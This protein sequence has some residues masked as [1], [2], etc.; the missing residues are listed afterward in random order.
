[1]LLFVSAVGVVLVVSFLC[2]IYE[3]VLL[4]VRRPRIEV[5]TREGRRS[6][7]LL[8]KF[9]DNM[10]VPIAAILILN[11]AAHT[12]GAAVAGASYSNVF[13]PS[14]LWLFS[15]LFTLAVLLFTEIIPKTLGVSYAAKLAPMVAHGIQWLT[16][17]LKPLVVVSEKI[18]RSIRGNVASPVTS[19]EEIRLLTVLG[20]AE[21]VVGPRT[22]Q[23]IVGASQ[24]S[25]L[26]A[27][28]VILPREEIRY[29]SGT[30]DRHTALATAHEARHSRFPFTPSGDLNDFTGV[31]LVKD[32]LHWLLTHEDEE[33]DWESL[34]IEPIVV[35]ESA[36]LTRLLRTFQDSR[37]HLA[38]VVDEYGSVEGLATLED[39]LE[40]IVGEIDDES[41]R[42]AKDI[43]E[44]DDGS[45]FVK[46]TVDLR[47]LSA[48]LGLQW[49]PEDDITTIGGLI[50]EELE[51]IPVVG[52]SI[53]WNGYQISVLRADRQRA[54][55]LSVKKA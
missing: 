46:A 41:D 6:G 54:K 21:G 40:E 30:M 3:S 36:P 45:L 12:I 25:V 8:A 2:S 37:R 35:P 51:R 24:L 17:A 31:V 43:M 39:V 13:D 23:M 9:K 16:I 20:G 19:I 18:S 38:I 52:D 55:L 22:A 32:L 5:L 49:E 33:V 27:R 53:T 15:L 14:T 29:L 48:N 44:R 11:T 34:R 26:K 50:S 47:K 1:M 10:D 28:D 42:P 4:T 7:R